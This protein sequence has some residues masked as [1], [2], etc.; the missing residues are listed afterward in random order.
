MECGGIAPLEGHTI[1]CS[2]IGC[3]DDE[4]IALEV[5]ACVSQPLFQVL[6]EMRAPVQGN[7]AGAVDHLGGDHDVSR[8]LEDLK[9]IVVDRRQIRWRVGSNDTLHG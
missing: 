6:A 3:F 7:D 1:V 9:I 2:E 4:R 5:A 8:T